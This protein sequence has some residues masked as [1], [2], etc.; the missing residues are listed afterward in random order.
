MLK[1]IIGVVA[2]A[3]VVALSP[4]AG[5]TQGVVARYDLTAAP[6]LEVNANIR[7]HKVMG[8]IG[9]FM[10]GE[11][12]PG[13]K[14]TPHHHAHDQINVG[15]S[16]TF[17]IVTATKPYPVSRLRGLFVLPNVSHGNLVA[18]D[19]APPLLI[20]FQPVRRTDFPPEREKVTFPMAAAPVSPS[21]N[22]ELDF[23]PESRTWQRQPSGVRTSASRGTAAAVAAWEIPASLTTPIEI[24]P[25]LPGAEVFAYVVEGAI[26][27][28]SQSGR[29]AA[30][31]GTLL[32]NPPNA[33]PLQVRSSNGTSI[34]LIFEATKPK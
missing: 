11:F 19:A 9:T 25:Q 24:P 3:I 26:D 10:L 2:A 6:P 1:P 20:E 22:L 12:A 21:D 15:I 18:A 31:A 30:P 27:A 33:S 34:L 8:D 7:I 4:A 17:D 23:R 32:V 14:S 13:F 29:H 28:Q 5:G 16:N